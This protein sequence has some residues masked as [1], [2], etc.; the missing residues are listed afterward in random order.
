MLVNYES[1]LPCKNHGKHSFCSKPSA[2]VRT[3]R[4][5]VD[6]KETN[7]YVKPGY[8]NTNYKYTNLQMINYLISK[9][10]IYF[11]PLNLSYLSL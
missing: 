8:V 4:V 9:F 11:F 3:E 5:S 7:N 1:N 2:I 10:N 6:E